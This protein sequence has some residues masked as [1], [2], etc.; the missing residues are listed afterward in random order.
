MKKISL[1]ILLFGIGVKSQVNLTATSGVSA[2]SYTTV[3]AAFDAINLGTHQGEIKLIITANT[4]ET[5]VAVLNAVSTYNSIIIKPDTGKTVTISGSIASNPI[6]R[7]LGSNVSIDGSNTE[8][9]ISRDLTISNA[10]PTSP[11]VIMAGAASNATPFTNFTIK[12]TVI[13]N[14]SNLAGYA[15]SIASGNLTSGGYFNN[16]TIKNNEIK[17]AQYAIHTNANTSV[18]GNGAN[19]LIDG[20]LL[21]TNIRNFGIFVNGVTGSSIVRN[22]TI[23]LNNTTA[24]SSTIGIN[25]GNSTGN[26]DIYGNVIKD[27]KHNV[28]GANGTSN[29]ISGI[30]VGSG[31]TRPIKIHNNTISNFAGYAQNLISGGISIISA[32]GNVIVNANKISNMSNSFAA[33][34]ASGIVLSSTLPN[35]GILVSNNFISDISST[36]SGDVYGININQGSGYKLYNNTVNINTNHQALSTAL[37]VSSTVPSASGLDIRNNIFANTQ[38]GGIPYSIYSLAPNS[39][40]GDLDF[41]NYYSTGNLGFIGSIRSSLADLMTGFGTNSNSRSFYPIFV[42]ETDPHLDNRYNRA[43]DNLGTPLPDVLADI[44]NE[45]RNTT[46]PDIGAHE[47]S[48][49]QTFT[50]TVCT[51]FLT[52]FNSATNIGAGNYNFTWG[53]AEGATSY[54]L[55]VGISPGTSDVYNEIVEGISKSL[56]L[57]KNS[58]YYSKIIPIHDNIATSGCAEISFSTGNWSYC[59]PIV[60]TGTIYPI[61]SLTINGSTFSSSSTAGYEDLTATTID[62]EKGKS[63]PISIMATGL[64][65]SRYAATVFIDWNQDGDF[66]HENES[67]FNLPSSIMSGTAVANTLASNLNVPATATLGNTRMRIKYTFNNNTTASIHTTLATPCSS[68][69]NGQIEDYTVNVI[70]ETLGSISDVSSA[71]LNVSPNPFT[72]LIYVSEPKNVKS[73]VVFDISGKIVRSI[74][75][76][77]GKSIDLNGL[78]TGL[79]I[80]N[81]TM[82]N[83]EVNSFKMVKKDTIP[84]SV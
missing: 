13:T 75:K 78:A 79:Y 41:N 16:I 54:K 7:I 10:S 53:S 27:F 3:K 57:D 1:L 45:T 37:Y 46:T 33:N 34:P 42:S 36:N 72:D 18:D 21:V 8:D 6:L 29:L 4:T 9:G 5:A 59:T 17:N 43:L 19:L 74:H 60:A 62:L 64:A 70:D 52:P 14:G 25:I 84:Q 23:T 32:T 2:Q 66:D 48:Y 30:Y 20:N 76:N 81:L 51:N 39:V 71:K 49:N 47:Y 61:N 12:N 82:N 69:S 11:N 80:I 63:Y 65:G 26:T 58:T 44:D 56:V 38:N 31:G 28:S 50:T 55:Q 40:F 15:V 22:N 24:S 68:I 67:Y 35:S 73:V 77:I 83:G